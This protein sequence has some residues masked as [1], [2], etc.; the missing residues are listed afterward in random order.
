LTTAYDQTVTSRL[1]RE[2]ADRRSE[3]Q[4]LAERLEA[5]RRQLQKTVARNREIRAEATGPR[6][7]TTQKRSAGF[8]TDDPLA[9]ARRA[10]A[11]MEEH[12]T[13]LA[14]LADRRARAVHRALARGQSRSDV[15]RSLGVSRQAITKLLAGRP[16]P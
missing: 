10:A 16:A 2:L 11:A 8:E 12:R 7:T 1:E 6:R 15:A 9:D 3:V 14:D 5:T 13:A 4:A